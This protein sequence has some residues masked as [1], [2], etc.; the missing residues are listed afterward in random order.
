MWCQFSLGRSPKCVWRNFT[1]LAKVNTTIPHYAN[2]VDGPSLNNR[3]ISERKCQHFLSSSSRLLRDHP[4]N[5]FC[6]ISVSCGEPPHQTVADDSIGHCRHAP[7]RG[8]FLRRNRTLDGQASSGYSQGLGQGFCPGDWSGRLH[9]PLRIPCHNSAKKYDE[10][11]A[12][13]TPGGA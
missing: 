13:R 2:L 6:A 7:E 5:D 1:W 10:V 12:G 8:R 4:S 11:H 3:V 9:S